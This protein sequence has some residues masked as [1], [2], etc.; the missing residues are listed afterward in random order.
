MAGSSYRVDDLSGMRISW[1]VRR[2]I[3]TAKKKK[4][5]GIIIYG[6][7]KTGPQSMARTQARMGVGERGRLL[8][9]CS[10]H[11]IFPKLVQL[12]PGAHQLDFLGRA[13]SFKRKIL[14]NEGDI[15]IAICEPAHSWALFA[16]KST[17]D[18][19]WMGIIDAGGR[20]RALG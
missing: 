1:I 17:I 11:S 3:A 6:I 13:D 18:K 10:A 14:L 15:L 7:I 19:W 16:R 5:T 12:R 2:K 9:F 8:G 20:V 4:I